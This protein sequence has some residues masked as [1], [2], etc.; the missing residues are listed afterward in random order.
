MKYLLLSLLLLA[1]GD[2]NPRNTFRF[3]CVKD[4]K[5]TIQHQYTSCLG[6]RPV[7]RIQ[8]NKGIWYLD[9]STY[10]SRPGEMCHYVVNPYEGAN[11]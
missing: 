4:G 7:F 6:C 8:G 11:Q 5:D 1:G 10:I 9:G 2:V 3:W